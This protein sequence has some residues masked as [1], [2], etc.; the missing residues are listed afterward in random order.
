ME[1]DKITQGCTSSTVNY[2][3]L[4]RCAD[5]LNKAKSDANEALKADFISALKRM[6][7]NDKIIEKIKQKGLPSH[8]IVSSDIFSIC[9][10]VLSRY[11]KVVEMQKNSEHDDKPILMMVW[12]G[13]KLIH[14]IPSNEDCINAAKAQVEKLGYTVIKIEK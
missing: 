2:T 6:G 1:N 8:I 5:L 4:L 12:A 11:G 9:H 3:D 10:Q 13:E 14:P 7:N